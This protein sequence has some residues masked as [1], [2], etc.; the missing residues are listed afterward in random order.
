MGMGGCY[1]IRN[2][3]VESGVLKLPESLVGHEYSWFA[4]FHTVLHI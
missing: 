4:I 3:A 2:L 1:L